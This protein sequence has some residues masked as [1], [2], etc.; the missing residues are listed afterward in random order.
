MNEPTAAAPAT[1]SQPFPPVAILGAGKIGQ[2]LLQ[3]ILNAEIVAPSDIRITRRSDAAAASLAEVFHVQAY[4]ESSDPAANQ[5]AVQGAGVAIVAVKPAQVVELLGSLADD[6]ADNVV[7]ISVAAGVKIET[8]AAVLP[9]G[10]TVLRA[11]PNTPALIG[12]AVTGLAAAPDAS[13]GALAIGKAL[14]ATVG[15]V[16]VVDE[17]RI[18]ALTAISGSGPAYVFNF[19]EHFLSAARERGF[20]EEEAKTLVYGTVSG[21]VELLVHSDQSPTVLREQVTSPGGTTA[22]AISIFDAAGLEGILDRATA[23][24]EARA[25]ELSGS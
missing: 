9:K 11:M 3:G 22:A 18:D 16:V 2:A 15:D 5:K 17:S 24:A 8:M 10:A 1:A 6:L 25:A 12:R 20:S 4:A 23:A 13:A 19:V 14:F 21:A 7:V